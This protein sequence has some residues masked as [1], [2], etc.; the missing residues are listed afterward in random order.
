M[1]F[2]LQK[3]LIKLM[4]NYSH[5]TSKNHTTFKIYFSEWTSG[6]LS[7]W[8]IHKSLLANLLNSRLVFSKHLYL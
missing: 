6:T 7:A 8:R 1:A 5:V 2:H 3:Y 4:T